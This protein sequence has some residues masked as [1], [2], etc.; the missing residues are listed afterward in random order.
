ML[1]DKTQRDSTWLNNVDLAEFRKFSHG[2]YR[3]A[4]YDE[5]QWRDSCTNSEWYKNIKQQL[6]AACKEIWTAS[7]LP[8]NRPTPREF[9]YNQYWNFNTFYYLQNFLSVKET[10]YDLGCGG[11]L[12]KPCFKNLIGIDP[13]HPNADIDD[14]CDEGFIDGHQNFFQYVFAINSLHFI[15][16]YKFSKTI[17][18]FHNMLAPNGLGYIS[19]G[20]AQ[21]VELTTDK[22]WIELFGKNPNNTN[23]YDVINFINTLLQSLPYNFLILD[24]NYFHTEDFRL[25]TGNEIDGNIRLL[26]KR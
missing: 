10:V 9:Q 12:F 23:L 17:N 6:P 11:N 24:Q 16:L 14:I 20:L 22:E 1:Y 5:Q 21:M 15:S 18:D 3:I 2:L 4:P 25:I 8:G 26:I 19:F 7:G 13:F